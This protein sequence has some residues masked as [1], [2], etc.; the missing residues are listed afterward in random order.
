MAPANILNNIRN[1]PCKSSCCPTANTSCRCVVSASNGSTSRPV[2]SNC[3]CKPVPGSRFV[4]SNVVIY[5]YNPRNAFL[6]V[7][8]FLWR[9]IISASLR[10][11]SFSGLLSRSNLLF[12]KF[13]NTLYV[14]SL[15][16]KNNPLL[17]CFQYV[18]FIL[19][20]RQ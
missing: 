4:L 13:S 20:V 11:F 2:N 1:H 16:N 9:F 7:C 15:S 5:S 3:C 17:P 10:D 18:N 14:T 12:S 8:K 6:I 19:K